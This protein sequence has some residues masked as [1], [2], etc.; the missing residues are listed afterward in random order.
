MISI[1]HSIDELEKSQT[2][3]V[4]V[5]DCYLSAIRNLADYAIK[6]RRKSPGRTRGHATSLA[7]DVEMGGPEAVS[8]S[9]SSWRGLLPDLR[10]KAR[11]YIN[12]LLGELSRTAQALARLV[13]S[14]LQHDG[15]HESRFCQDPGAGA[16]CASVAQRPEASSSASSSN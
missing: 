5:L 16:H 15:D 9:R 7:R 14:M 10:D 1:R 8:E 13:D 6:L 3:R 12:Q 11:H 2:L 4:L